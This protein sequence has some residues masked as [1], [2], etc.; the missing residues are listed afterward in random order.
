M[1]NKLFVKNL[2]FKLDESELEKLFSSCGQVTSTF[3][4]K[5]RE[6]GRPRGFGFVE[7][8]NQAEAEAAIRQLDNKE[9]NERAISVSLAEARPKKTF[10]GGGSGGQRKRY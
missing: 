10:G 9:V 6:T 8:S 7:M 4:A 1:N 2:S 3:I 5:D